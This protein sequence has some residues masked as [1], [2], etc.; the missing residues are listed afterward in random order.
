MIVSGQ[1]RDLSYKTTEYTEYQAF[2]PV[3]RIGSPPQTPSPASVWCSPPLGPR[4]E[5]HSLGGEGVRGPNSDEGTDSL[6]LYEYYYPISTRLLKETLASF[7]APSLNMGSMLALPSAYST[8]KLHLPPA[9][10]RE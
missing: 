9:T 5:T 8:G 1:L 7:K 6:V 2:C 3:V 4:G 10:Q